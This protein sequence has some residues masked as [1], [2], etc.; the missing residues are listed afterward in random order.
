V[1]FVVDVSGSI[2]MHR[3]EA[4]RELLVSVVDA[5]DVGPTATRVGAVYFSTASYTAFTLDQYTTRQDVK[6][7]LRRIPY[8]GLRSNIAA[9]L[10]TARY[11]LLQASRLTEQQAVPGITCA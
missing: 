7:A 6:E 2:K 3:V 5:L 11:Q 10:R 8:E 9:G 1:I 4:V